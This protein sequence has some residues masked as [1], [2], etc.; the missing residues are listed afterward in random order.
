MRRL[1]IVL[2]ALTVCFVALAPRASVSAL[3][4]E[5][6]S[7]AY[8]PGEVIVKLKEHARGVAPSAEAARSVAAGK[9]R[10]RDDAALPLAWQT[11]NRQLNQLISRRGLDRTFVL[12]FDRDA[13]I[14]MII[15]ELEA[16][17][18]VEYAEPNYLVT[19]GAVLPGDPRFGDQ[20]PLRNLG[21]GVPIRPDYIAA[22]TLDADIKAT[23]AWGV[24]TGNPDTLVAVTDSGIDIEHPDL[25]DN[26][27]INEGE[28]P[29]N[30][31][32]D[33]RNGFVDDRNGYNAADN[34]GDV[35]DVTGHGTLMAGVIAAGMDN[36]IGISGVS[37]AKLL[38]VRFFKKTGPG[39]FDFT[40]TVAD[41]ARALLY[42]VA[43]GAKIINASWFTLLSR[44]VPEAEAQALKDAVAATSDAGALLV[45]IA[46]NDGFNNDYVKVYPGAYRLPNQIV[47]AATDYNDVIWRDWFT[48]ISG[49]GPNS[50]HLAAP[51]VSILT[52]M[53]RGDC[54]GCSASGNPDDWYGR[55]D[56]TSASA[57]FVSGVAALVRSH[58]PDEDAIL[59]KRRILEGVDPLEGLR[60]LVITAG[61]LN[62]LGALN[63]QIHITP[64]ALTDYK[65]K[66][67]SGKL[68]VYGTDL[69]P[70]AVV[71]VGNSA[72]ALKAKGGDP[73]R[74]LARVPATAFPSGVAVPIKLRNPD[75]GTSRV[76]VV[77]R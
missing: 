4:V 42:S 54:V 50:V 36:Q 24:T 66:A 58:Y 48:V 21:L 29:G 65:Y 30:G 76:V 22:S 77:E 43:A 18:G 16:D 38:P 26:I 3:K 49:F 70:G 46:G 61:R 62:A 64:P 10:L 39:R 52:T 60:G 14:D 72:Y 34:N 11:T 75:G 15:A 51:G 1:L 23:L 57:A 31:V 67:G 2:A 8:A 13:D 6:A 56:G 45:C 20:W 41:A 74:W 7:P 28:I 17:E 53:A 35:S 73:A 40:A 33:D 9:G 63:A 47:V 59:T 37:R 27:Y 32:D 12:K 44:D 5:P 71:L 68:L 25:A 69:Q 19:P 55:T